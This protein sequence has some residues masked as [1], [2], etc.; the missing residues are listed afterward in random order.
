MLVG[1]EN[2]TQEEL[3]QWKLW[4]EL[5]RPRVVRTQRGRNFYM[6]AVIAALSGVPAT[7]LGSLLVEWRTHPA[8]SVMTS[9]FWS[10]LPFIVGPLLLLLLFSVMLRRDRRLLSDGEIAIGKIVS[11]RRG[12]RRGWR[13]TYEFLDCSGQLITTSCYDNSRSVIEGAPI[14]VFFGR[15]NPKDK[16]IALCGSPYEV[17]VDR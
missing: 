6:V 2:P 1:P 10:A 11:V 13:V 4:Q 3:Q 5:P 17:A 9:D 8:K 16:Q 7:S 15:E 12:G 14:P